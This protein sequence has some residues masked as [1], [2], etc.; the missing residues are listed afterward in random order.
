MKRLRIFFAILLVLLFLPLWRLL[1][2]LIILWPSSILYTMAFTLMA[3]LTIIIPIHLLRPQWKP[4]YLISGL[5]LLSSLIWY[6]TPLSGMA[7]EN[8]EWR[9]CGSGTYSGFIY[10]IHTYLSDAHQDDI[11]A[12]NQLCWLRKIFVRLPRRFDDL[13]E[14]QTYTKILNRKL[15]S[16]EMKFRASLPM[17]ALIQ[18]YLATRMDND[19]FNNYKTGKSFV[20]SLYEWRLHYTVEI[21]SRTYSKW[22]WPHSSY[23]QFEYGLIERNWE[24]IIDGISIEEI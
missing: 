4:L 18:G 8:S 15:H 2:T 16:P 10:P 12:R 22:D 7:T 1:D 23:I 13:I 24:K 6:G 20:E 9:H 5:L 14:Y 19:A 11:E 3:T 21:S 17:I